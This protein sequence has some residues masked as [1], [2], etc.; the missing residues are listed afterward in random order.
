[1]LAGSGYEGAGAG[2]HVPVKRPVQGA[3]AGHQHRTRNLLLASLRCQGEHGFALLCQRWRT[4]Q[5][6]MVS[7]SRIGDI[8]LTQFEHKMIAGKSLR[9]SFAAGGVEGIEHADITAGEAADVA[10]DQDQTPHP[11]RGG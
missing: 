10:G 1:V 8:A 2:V 5:R 9:N 6:A 11:G 3:G 7:R 4:L